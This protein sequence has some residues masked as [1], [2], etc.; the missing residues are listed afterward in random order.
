MCVYI[1]FVCVRVRVRA[2]ECRMCSEYTVYSS[3]SSVEA[4][5]AGCWSK[6]RV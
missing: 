5:F 6:F 2:L 1:F 4:I 3:G